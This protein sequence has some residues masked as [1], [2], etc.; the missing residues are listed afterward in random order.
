MSQQNPRTVL[1]VDDERMTRLYHTVVLTRAGYICLEAADAAEAFS[2][3]RA[4][5][6]DLIMLDLFMPKISGQEFIK[7]F[8]A[9]PKFMKVPVL[10]ISAEPDGEKLR[11]EETASAGSVEFL[12]KPLAPKA[13]LDAV[14]RLLA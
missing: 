13:L 2:H 11:Q 6:V 4:R 9:D 12:Q 5:H 3:L 14:A 8:R 1:V 10:V 7:G